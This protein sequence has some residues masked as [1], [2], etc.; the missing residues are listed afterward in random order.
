M[1]VCMY[2]GRRTPILLGKKINECSSPAE[3]ITVH[4]CYVQSVKMYV[5][6]IGWHDSSP[7]NGLLNV[8]WR[9][10]PTFIIRCRV[11]K[12]LLH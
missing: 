6:I 11:E 7:P 8:R 5:C 12:F 1:Y 9:S 3:K 10:R 2:V 4:D